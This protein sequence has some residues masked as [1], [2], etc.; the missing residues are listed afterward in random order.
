MG[1]THFN[2]Q[3]KDYHFPLYEDRNE[4]TFMLD[5]GVEASAYIA[6]VV[7]E[8]DESILPFETIKE[9]SFLSV[10]E[11]FRTTFKTTSSGT[12][13]RLTWYKSPMTMICHRSFNKVDEYL[14]Y[15]GGLIG[16]MV[17][18]LFIMSNFSEKAYGVS[19]ANSVYQSD[20]GKPV[21]SNRFHFFY[22]L[23]MAV[24]DFFCC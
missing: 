18:L 19:I 22:T 13:V 10:L 24:R 6:E 21:D 11:P 23:S 15:V 8:T 1:S 3:Q 2:A 7:A 9:E 17:A 5:K 16:A 14:A 4:F 12:Y 20:D